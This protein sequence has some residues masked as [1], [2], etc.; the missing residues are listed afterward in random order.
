MTYELASV[1]VVT[2]LANPMNAIS[3]ALRR[4]FGR[5]MKRRTIVGGL[6]VFAV[7]QVGTLPLLALG[8]LA[9]TT[10]HVDALYFAIIGA[11]SVVLEGLVA[12]FVIV[13]AVD[14][15]VRREGLD[16]LAAEAPPVVA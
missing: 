1:A 4:A 2:E 6:V 14:V 7:S 16:I 11:G 8:A 9:A 3:T 5:G 13:F 15:R 12:A 10:T